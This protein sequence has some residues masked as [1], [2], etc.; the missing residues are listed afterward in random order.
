MKGFPDLPPLWLLGFMALAWA[1]ARFVPVLEFDLGVL[2]VLGLLTSL[3]GV[4]LIFWAASW[5]FRKKTTIEPHH[6]PETLIT[7]GPFARSRN[8][9]YLGFLLIL[10]GQIIWQG[11]L[12]P[13]VTLPLLFVVLDR[14][15]ASVEEDLV[16]DVFGE[17]GKAYVDGTP[18]WL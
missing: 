2:R 4:G 13:L 15:F 18:R 1:L 12:S 11:A 16:T 9:I 3:S 10:L 5:F 17:I 8:P 6:S 14:R 7:E